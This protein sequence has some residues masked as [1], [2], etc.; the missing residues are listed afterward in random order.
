MK[1]NISVLFLLL[2]LVA[3][4][5]A[6]FA[7][8][9]RASIRGTVTDPNGAVVAGASVTLI[10]E[11]TNERRTV[12]SNDEGE[13][14]LAALPPAPYLIEVEAPNFKRQSGQRIVLQVNQEARLNVRLDIGLTADAETVYGTAPLLEQ[15][16]PALGTVIEER[17]IRELPLDGRNFLE[18]ALLAP[19]TAPSA[20]GS[21]GSVR[22][23]FAF[24]AN[25]AR[26]DS[27]NFL[28]DGVYNLDPKL[29]SFGVRPPVDG[30]Q[31]FEISTSTYDASFGRNSGAQV[32]VVSKSGTNTL[33]GTLYEF[34]RNARF[35]ARN[36]FAPADQPDP[37]YIRNQFGFSLG[38]AIRR[39]RTFFFGDYEGTRTREGITR[40]T[41]VPTLR[42][43][44]GDFSQSRDQFG[45]PVFVRNPFAIDPVTGTPL[46][47]GLILG[48][49]I[50]AGCFP[51]QTVPAQFQNSI[52]RAIANLYPLPNR[53][54]PF[55]NFV[56]SPTSTDRND[57]FDLRFDHRFNDRSTFTTRYS[58]GDR[59]LFEPFTG[60]TF[61]LVPGF[62]NFVPR[63]SQNLM[64]SETHVFSPR[65]VNEARFA[66][67]RVASAV[68]AEG[69]GRSLNQQVGLPELSTNPRD[70]GL[71]FITITGYSP[72]GEEFNNPQQSTS[73]VFQFL[74][75]ATLV[76]GSHLAKFGFEFRALQ[77]NAFRDVQSRGFLTFSNSFPLTGNALADLL[78][79]FPALTG[80]ARLDNHQHLRG[81]SY[82][83]YA[84]DSF[85]VTPRLTLSLGLR[86]EY[87]SPPVDAEDR[88]NLYDPATRTLSRV[89]TNGI[90][91]SGYEADKN[92][93]A[94]RVGL[95]YTLNDAGTTVLRGG[96]GVY[97]DQ[98][99]LAP[100]EGLYFNAPY[101]DF[102]LYFSLPGLPLTVNNPFP[103]N[104]PFPLPDTALAFQRDL[105]TAYMQHWNV[106]IQ[107]QLGASRVLEIG[108]AGSKGTKLLTARDINQPRPSTLPF[109]LRP[110]PQFDDI[111][112]IESRGNSNY[113]SLQV[114]LQQRLTRGLA[115][116]SSYTYAKSI[117]DASNF[118]TSAGD[119]N[120]PQDSQNLRLE[121]GRSNFDVR[122][123]LSASFSYELPFGRGRRFLSD[124]GFATTLLSGFQFNGILTLQTGR[125]FTVAL[126]SEIDNSNTG[127]STL[128]FGANDRPNVVGD[129]NASNRTPERWFNTDAFT[130]PPSGTFGNAG[131]NVIDG[132]GY[133]NFNASLLKNTR[134]SERI[135]LQLRLEAF[136]LFNHPNFNLPDNFLGSPTFGQILSARDPRHLQFGAK[137]LF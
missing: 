127:R 85:R 34:H 131:R 78:L 7:Q 114:R 89:G 48:T 108:Y 49:A 97:Y 36:F 52:G 64:L 6:T 88:A 69:R 68:T 41:N 67:S 70:F 57:H 58:F 33:H 73:N 71:S 46:P 8:T 113:H 22:G 90:P 16:T 19:G 14:S 82:A 136:N 54:V 20:P 126:L 83:V 75:N 24:S 120:F 121:R 92:N 1:S 53:N 60:P 134:L 101:F 137:L 76:R 81:E 61:S 56:S 115:L 15:D 28:L 80:G 55:A 102:N 93:F 128:G 37:K 66:F 129:P 32:N 31:E 106:N 107:Q 63:R 116:L 65:V 99:A 133:Q 125:P 105:R 47:C 132:P 26:E 43:R 27:N 40:V 13:Y 94:P 39:D 74:D 30:I 91:R 9:H 23:D 5:P 11:T 98:P 17:Q 51:N 77:Q 4:A 96:Y 109:V 18:L 130:F 79:G 135:N 62:G 21:A 44:N 100:G 123:R 124:E 84:N 112:L 72:L 119:P 118:F 110:V 111:N 59:D 3:C 35:D 122:H 103:Q 2:V 29:N 50:T 38:G 45:N 12:V 87:N 25:G 104:F 10:N 86:Y 117:D 42:E 95:A